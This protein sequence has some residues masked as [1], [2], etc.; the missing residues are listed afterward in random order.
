M[1]GLEGLRPFFRICQLSGFLPYRIEINKELGR[2]E[3]LSFSWR[4]PITWWFIFIS[5]VNSCIHIIIGSLIFRNTTVNNLP[6]AVRGTMMTVFVSFLVLLLTV[7]Y[8]LAFRFQTLCKAIAFLRKTED[9]LM[10]NDQYLVCRCTVKQRTIMGL[11]VTFLWV[12]FSIHS[13][14]CL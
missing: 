13:N 12:F 11:I 9:S 4:F 7:R 3:K 14:F 10:T 8:L 2:F 6:L 1:S 5:V